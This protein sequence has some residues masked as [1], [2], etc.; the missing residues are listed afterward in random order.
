MRKLGLLAMVAAG[1]W[2][3]GGADTTNGPRGDGGSGGSGG[4]GGAGGVAGTAGVGGL[5][6]NGGEGGFDGTAG[7]GGAGGVAGSG[8]IAMCSESADCEDGD[9]CTTDA[10]N[11]DQGMCEQTVLAEGTICDFGGGAGV[12]Q[13]GVCSADYYWRTPSTIE[14]E[15]GIV[16]RSDVAFKPNGDAVVVWSQEGE[17]AINVWAVEYSRSLGWGTPQIISPTGLDDAGGPKIAFDAGGDGMAVWRQREVIG[18]CYSWNIW[19]SRYTKT[20]GFQ[21]P[22][23]I[24]D[25]GGWA[26]GEP[27]LAMNS[28]GDAVATW[29]RKISGIPSSSEIWAAVYTEATGWGVAGPV[30]ADGQRTFD[31]PVGIDASGNAVAIWSDDNDIHAS[32]YEV[33]TGWSDA[34]LIENNSGTASASDIA[35]DGDGNAIAVWFG[36]APAK[37]FY[38]RYTV[39]QGWG[40]DQLLELTPNSDSRHPRVA[41]DAAGAI[42][43]VWQLS[44]PSTGQKSVR[45]NRYV[46]GAGWGLAE[47]ISEWGDGFNGPELAVDPNGSAVVAWS[48]GYNGVHATY[49]NRF[50]ERFGWGTAEH[51][52]DSNPATSDYTSQYIAVDVDQQGRAIAT[53]RRGPS[54]ERDLW[55]NRFE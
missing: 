7:V 34:V 48:A 16:G 1:L 26:T 22:Q 50:T 45:A 30:V 32:R 41:V 12:C 10:C 18:C 42:V 43:A 44:D 28:R 6:G 2:A 37:V 54:P 55:A 33:G 23:P 5:G 25:T 38:N 3:C 49:A 15:V 40:S 14:S 13:T 39:G 27:R 53:W 17:T 29:G 20:E 36:S 46:P 24:G 51:I 47:Q 31:A 21:P 4:V 52:D 11:V 9:E 8:G 19:A 35:V